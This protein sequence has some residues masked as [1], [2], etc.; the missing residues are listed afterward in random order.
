MSASEGAG[1]DKQPGIT[2][3]IARIAMGR[4]ILEVVI[5]RGGGRPTHAEAFVFG[6][7]VDALLFEKALGSQLELITRGR[8]RLVAVPWGQRE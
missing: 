6:D 8:N 4:E 1:V 7:V 2:M 3:E 5:F